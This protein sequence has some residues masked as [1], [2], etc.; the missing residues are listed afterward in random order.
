M[1][2]NIFIGYRRD[3]SE[4]FSG[5]LHGELATSFGDDKVFIDVTSM[6]AGEDFPVQLRRKLDECNV[7]LAPIGPK[8]LTLR[9][10]GRRFWRRRIDDPRDWLRIEIE[11]GLKRDI[12]VIPV[13]FHGAR[14]PQAHEL[15]SDIAQLAS[16]QNVEIR[17]RYFKEDVRV[18]KDRIELSLLERERE[19]LKRTAAT[20]TAITVGSLPSRRKP[21]MRAR[22]AAALAALF[23]AGLIVVSIAIVSW[24]YVATFLS[25]TSVKDPE[26]RRWPATQ[27]ARG[28]AE[29]DRRVAEAAAAK[30]EQDRLAVEAQR[31]AEQ[32]QRVAEAAAAKAEQDRLAVE[33]QRKAEQDRRVAEA[34][35]AKAEK[36]RLV[37][38]AQR[39]AEQD[40]R[41][42][43]AAAAKAEKDRLV[44]EAQRKAEQEQRAAEAAAA[45]AEA[46]RKARA[47]AQL[48]RDFT[49]WLN[50]QIGSLRPDFGRMTG[51]VNDYTE[52]APP[53]SF[54]M[55]IDWK[56]S[57]PGAMRR[58]GWGYA[59]A[60]GGPSPEARA[61]KD[62]QV[63]AVPA[64]SC[65]TV[66]RNGRQVIEPPQWWLERHSSQ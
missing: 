16:R 41:V 66:H 59:T 2:P 51:R 54:A 12:I 63:K 23:I 47:V 1:Q 9:G 25:P 62:C 52:A 40:R 46:E 44:A 60:G 49:S 19:P 61:I 6:R 4:L 22:S 31:K 36:D 28:K 48:K 11:T 24:K 33:A 17:P 42:A 14:M 56:E 15:P 5:R 58:R 57:T 65:V 13:L 53:K 27:E 8:W 18:L 21:E 29:Q 3:D 7:F 50:S 64:C 39:K 26:T 55:C 30:A 43:E 45:K 32:E 35:A 20:T 34:A 10:R 38:E 37:A